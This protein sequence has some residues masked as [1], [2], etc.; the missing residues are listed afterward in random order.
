MSNKSEIEIENKKGEKENYQCDLID[1]ELT[2]EVEENIEKLVK[3]S[4]GLNIEQLFGE[5]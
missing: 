1:C 2:K 3:D 4:F 5:N